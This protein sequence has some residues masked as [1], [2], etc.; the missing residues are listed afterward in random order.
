[1]ETGRIDVTFRDFTAA[2][3]LQEA[4]RRLLAGDFAGVN[5][6]VNEETTEEAP[7]VQQAPEEAPQE[8]LPPVYLKYSR[9]A[10]HDW[11][12]KLTREELIKI[13][14]YDFEVEL[15]SRTRTNTL[16]AEL[17][18]LILQK[19]KEVNAAGTGRG[20][21]K[22]CAEHTGAVKTAETEAPARGNRKA[23]F[24]DD[25]E[26]DF[27]DELDDNDDFDDFEDEA[28]KLD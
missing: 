14:A 4:M 28:D 17:E 8:T 19:Q 5:L 16:M 7:Q 18:K 24:E 25:I 9:K 12:A 23:E 15:P 21:E 13:L 6:G 2:T 22:V 26:D 20:T 1:M 27:E 11:I 3:K 10:L